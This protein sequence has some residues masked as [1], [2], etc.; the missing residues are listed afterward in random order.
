MS[1]SSESNSS[2]RSGKALLLS[3]Q[4]ILIRFILVA[5]TDPPKYT[6]ILIDNNKY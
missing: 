3:A 6:V 4:T 2:T 5:A 1:K